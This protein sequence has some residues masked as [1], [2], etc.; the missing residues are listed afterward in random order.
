MHS[1]F[2]FSAL[3][4]SAV[5]LPAQRADRFERDC[6]DNWSDRRREHFCEV[7]E[8]RMRVPQR[9]LLVD[10]GDNG[11]V[12]F[13]GWDRDE[14][15]VRAMIRATGESRRDAEELARAVRI[16]VSDDRIRAEGPS[17]RNRY[18]DWSV[19]YE[20]MVPRRI[21]L[22]A[23][24]RNGGISV[25]QVDGRME[26]EAENGGISVRDAGG[27]ISAHTTNG[28][29]SAHL[30]GTSWR[31]EHL[32]LRTS[33]GGVSLNIPRGYN[34]ELETGTVNGGMEIDFPITIQGR[35]NRRIRTTLGR[36]GPTVRAVTTNG[37]V[38][39]RER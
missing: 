31:G 37:G 18:S 19:S 7:R 23:N 11:G 30:T 24:T 34:A 10:G 17:T 20:V 27:D 33:N 3:L 4:L 32:D 6:D 29:V 5:A 16:D 22:A 15:L 14:V 28:G 36:G 26:F 2:V 38:K 8:S 35:I 39:I 12:S 21:N 25:E 13:Y 1:R 9:Q